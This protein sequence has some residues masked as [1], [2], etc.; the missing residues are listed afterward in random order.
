MNKY[1]IGIDQSTQGTKAMLFNEKGEMTARADRP[2]KQYVDEKGW[3]EHDG[4]EI[5]DNTIA[6][7][8]EILQKSGVKEEEICGVGISNQ[9]ETAIAWDRKT[10]LPVFHAVVWQCNRGEAIC[11]RLDQGDFSRIIQEKTGLPL[12]PYYSD[13]KLAWIVENVPEAKALAD[14]D[15]L[16]CGTMDS[17]LL[18]RLTKGKSF[19]T[20]YSNASRTQ[21]LNINTLT[22]DED[23][24][25]A[26]G[27]P[28]SAMPELTDSDGYFGETDF[29]GLFKKPVPIHA[30]LGDS[31]AALYGH[32]CFE[33]G[34]AK[35]TYGTGSSIMMNIGDVPLRNDKGLVTSVAFK[36]NGKLSYCLEGNINYSAAIVSWLKDDLKLICTPGE[37]EACA[38]A[39]N[40]ADRTYLVPAFTGLGAPYYRSDVSAA[41][42]GMSRNTG[43]NELVKAGLEAIVY[44]ITDIVKLCR[45]AMGLS[46]I[47][48]RAD[49]GASGNAWLMQFQADIL[50]DTVRVSSEGELSAKGAA[51]ACGRALGVFPAEEQAG[52]AVSYTPEMDQ[53]AAEEKYEGWKKAVSLLL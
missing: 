37:S 31:H 40:P 19:K 39:A 23:I 12:A 9:R 17:Y 27:L 3:V 13:S 22:W 24:L 49:G 4:I 43:K 16:C 53:T 45:E 30:M 34:M 14:K 47:E 38:K 7:V 1:M 2:H 8:K 42:I 44:Q 48:L 6:I 5:Y 26:F 18:Y 29:E 50:R 35:V 25:K 15:E 41:F 10:G 21:L 28:L 46:H 11:R 32:G 51:L 36:V 33:K 52:S 20:D